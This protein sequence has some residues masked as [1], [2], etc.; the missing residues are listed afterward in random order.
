[1]W[2]Y[3]MH[4]LLPVRIHEYVVTTYA[5]VC[6]VTVCTYVRVWTVVCML[7]VPLSHLIQ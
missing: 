2:C 7:V 1:M 3:C 4:L 6:G 5:C